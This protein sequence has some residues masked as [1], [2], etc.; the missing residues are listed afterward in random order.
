MN[1]EPASA[2]GAIPATQWSLVAH[3]GRGEREAV[4]R[5]LSAYRRP[6]VTHLTIR[7]RLSV[8]DAEDLVQSFILNKV[9]AT[10]IVGLADRSRGRFRNFLLTAL[11]NYVRDA[12]RAALADK[13]APDRADSLG[14]DPLHAPAAPLD[15]PDRAFDLEWARTLIERTI[16]RMEQTCSSAEKQQTLML[17]R[18]RVLEPA[19]ENS[20]PASYDELVT[21]FGFASP[22]QASNALVTA[23][24]MF[25]RLLREIIAE[26]VAGDAEID[27]EINDL[28]TII[29][30]SAA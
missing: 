12:T 8:P 27:L 1:P 4:A 7:Q 13:R 24:R 2:M 14:D 15:S 29:S 11:D 30:R 6:L 23:K 20:P 21:R 19:L 25:R 28:F 16:A 9:V 22:L 17:F 5:F 26:Y 3:A 10:N 18:A